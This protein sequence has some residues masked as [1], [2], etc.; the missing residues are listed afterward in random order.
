MSLC[1]RLLSRANKARILGVANVRMFTRLLD[2]TTQLSCTWLCGDV[3]GQT[4]AQREGARPNMAALCTKDTIQL[5]MAWELAS[6]GRSSLRSSRFQISQQQTCLVQRLQ[7]PPHSARRPW[8][9]CC[10]CLDVCFKSCCADASGREWHHLLWLTGSVYS[11]LL[12]LGPLP[13]LSPARSQCAPSSPFP[14]QRTPSGDIF[15]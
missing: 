14:L 4:A 5:L 8:A 13:R 2:V 1:C 3:G 11:L 15:L 7:R 12:C 10:L 9:F 6:S